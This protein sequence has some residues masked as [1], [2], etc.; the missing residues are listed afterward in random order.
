MVEDEDWLFRPVMRGLCRY[1]SL[2]D[3]TLDLLDIA[4]MNEAMDVEAENMAR[5][6]AQ[7]EKQK[8]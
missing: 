2:R 6:R 8:G 7:A 4:L 5:A 3:G 1:E